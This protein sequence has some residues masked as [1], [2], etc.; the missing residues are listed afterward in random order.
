MSF[1][2][3]ERIDGIVDLRVEIIY[4]TRQVTIGVW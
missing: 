3:W 4:W 2:G 1:G